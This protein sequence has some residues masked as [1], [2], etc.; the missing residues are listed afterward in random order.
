MTSGERVGPRRAA[1]RSSRSRRAAR[2][3][4]SPAQRPARPSSVPSRACGGRRS[5]SGGRSRRWPSRGRGPARPSPCWRGYG[6]GRPPSWSRRRRQASGPRGCASSSASPRPASSRG[7]ASSLAAA[8]AGVSA[9]VVPA[10]AP[11]RRARARRGPRAG[12]RRAVALGAAPCGARARKARQDVAVV[13]VGF[14]VARR[15]GQIVPQLLRLPR[16]RRPKTSACASTV[17]ARASGGYSGGTR[18]FCRTGSM[19]YH[20]GSTFE[21]YGGVAYV[22]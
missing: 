22:P 2:W 4:R 15:H 9:R 20:E 12:P 16:G 5:G 19:P 14:G 21:R 6:P 17:S 13:A 18:R 10:P 8:A 7:R 3:A 11:S 1:G